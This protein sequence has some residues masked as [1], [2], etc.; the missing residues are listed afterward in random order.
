MNR[1]QAPWITDA[2]KLGKII[3]KWKIGQ[4]TKIILILIKIHIRNNFPKNRFP[5]YRTHGRRQ[6]KFSGGGEAVGEDAHG[7]G[8][9]DRGRRRKF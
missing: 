4:L 1:S 7:A 3:N 6:I 2:E 9:P 8:G 5:I